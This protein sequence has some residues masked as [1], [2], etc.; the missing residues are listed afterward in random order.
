MPLRDL[1]TEERAN[2]FR[3]WEEG[4]IILK[5]SLSFFIES[6]DSVDKKQFVNSKTVE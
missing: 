6:I 5:N 3:Q 1:D 4:A 2:I